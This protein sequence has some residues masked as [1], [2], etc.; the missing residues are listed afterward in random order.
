MKIC[1]IDGCDGKHKGY[2][3]CNRHYLKFKTYG[4]PLAIGR[5]DPNEI[6]IHDDYAEIILYKQGSDRNYHEYRRA[7]VDIEDVELVSGFRWYCDKDGYVKTLRNGT[8]LK[9]HRLIMGEPE[10][11][12]ID[13]FDH[14]KLNNRRANLIICTQLENNQ[15]ISM[16]KDNTSGVRGV[17]WR[18][19]SN[20]WRATIY[21]NKKTIN[22]GQFSSFNEAV[23]AR[24]DAEE[25]YFKNKGEM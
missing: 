6:I 25:K 19:D 3:Y 4:S 20:K 9:L 10:G 16:R 24:Q 7:M 12:V 22:L 5:K 17:H 14:N 13:H 23:K 15:N 1:N 11:K 8:R 18:K 21:V 2:G